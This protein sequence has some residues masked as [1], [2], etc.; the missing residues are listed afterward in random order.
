M[1]LVITE[2]IPGSTVLRWKIASSDF[3]FIYVIKSS[4]NGICMHCVDTRLRKC[5][6]VNNTYFNVN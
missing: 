4:L 3:F 5:E 6:L 1:F 2:H